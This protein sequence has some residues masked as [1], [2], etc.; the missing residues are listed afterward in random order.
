LSLKRKMRLQFEGKQD[1]LLALTKQ[2]KKQIKAGK[3]EE[4][5]YEK[6]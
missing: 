5:D 4:M 1:Q 2:V 6:L 3:V